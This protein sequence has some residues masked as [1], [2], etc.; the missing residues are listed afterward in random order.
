M[1]IIKSKKSTTSSSLR[2]KTK[3]VAATAKHQ[4]E[5][6]KSVKS[7]VDVS[8]PSSSSLEININQL[9]PAVV[10]RASDALLKYIKKELKGSLSTR[11]TADLF[12]DGVDD[13]LS[14]EFI[15]IQIG[16]NRIPSHA[17]PT[18]KGIRV[19]HSIF[20]GID[21][22]EIETSNEDGNKN[23]QLIT[24]GHGDV[25]VCLIVKDD[26]KA[27]AKRLISENQ[28]SVVGEVV[29]LTELR[30]DFKRF[31][32]KRNLRNTFDM[33]LADDRIVNMLLR[34]LGGTFV[35]R[36]KLPVP[37]RI[38]KAIKTESFSKLRSAVSWALH[39]TT[40]TI[41]TG[42]S[43]SVRVGHAGMSSSQLLENITAVLSGMI[44]NIPQ[45]GWRNIKNIG[46]RSSQSITLPIY[47]QVPDV[48][49]PKELIS[50]GENSI[51]SSRMS[52]SSKDS[53]KSLKDSESSSASTKQSTSTVKLG[54]Q[55]NDSQEKNSA[56]KLSSSIKTISK[57]AKMGP[58]ATKVTTTRSTRST[59]K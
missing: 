7:T 40:Y 8:T 51:L 10:S 56:V 44:P 3:S 28:F 54:K 43:L 24:E 34:T 49:V 17:N 32:D 23:N 20:A 18:P 36:K 26:S 33:F 48:F 53:E 39:T 35:R 13:A 52:K 41:P 42:A 21:Q 11:Q 58:R 15:Y 47:N 30:K 5:G 14:G 50:N 9:D 22:D 16:L 46:L 55:G 31:Q 4:K 12:V 59:K 25:E 38:A 6:I 29:T 37:V 19:P 2:T 1:A 57:T 45:G 27:V